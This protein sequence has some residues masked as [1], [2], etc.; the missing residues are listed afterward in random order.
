MKTFV[1]EE[2]YRGADLL[3][4]FEEKNILLCGAGAIGSNISE[5]LIRQGFKKLT[6]IDMDRIE[7]HNLNTQVWNQRSI[8]QTKVAALKSHLFNILKVSITDVFKELTES[9]IKKYFDL[10]MIVIDGFDN[11]KSRGLV[12]RYCQKNNIECL[13]IGL[14][15][16]CAEVTWN[17]S[18]HIPRDVEDLDVCE[19]PLARNIIMLAVVVGTESLIRFIDTGVKEN[20]LISLGDFKITLV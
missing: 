13:H 10:N 14:N 15:A 2:S 5:N 12:T 17:E 7:K 3:K 18:Y 9:N 1:H 8:G 20:Y 19:Y 16:D 11:S 6:V 4:K